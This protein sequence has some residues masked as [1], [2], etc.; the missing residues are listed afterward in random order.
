[1]P[2]VTVELAGQNNAVSRLAKADDKGKSPLLDLLRE[3]I[4]CG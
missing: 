4:D 3:L 1:M 2:G